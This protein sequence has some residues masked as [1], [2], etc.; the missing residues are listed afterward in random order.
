MKLNPTIFVLF[1]MSVCGCFGGETEVFR[2]KNVVAFE[3]TWPLYPILGAHTGK[4]I[5]LRVAE[6]TYNKVRGTKPYYLD[7][8][9]IHSIL[10][11]TE[12]GSYRVKFHIV[13]TE[14]KRGVTID[15][16]GSSFGWDIGS[17]AADA[18]KVEHVD[19]KLVVLVKFGGDWKEVT[20][21]NLQT[22]KVE[23]IQ[24]FDYDRKTGATGRER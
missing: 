18:D 22:L 8:P 20:S 16:S 2:D 21:L 13:D 6:K 3:K 15:G 11:V 19:S 7:L 10:F 9:Q 23:R 12:E 17:T 5:S 1:L 14:T 24:T 4:S